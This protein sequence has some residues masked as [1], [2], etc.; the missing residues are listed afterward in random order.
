MAIDVFSEANKHAAMVREL[1]EAYVR[2]GFTDGQ[3]MELLLTYIETTS[4]E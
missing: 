4:A 1:F 2:H 3:A